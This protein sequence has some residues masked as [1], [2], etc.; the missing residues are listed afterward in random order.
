[1]MMHNPSQGGHTSP[2]PTS[3]RIPPQAHTAAPRRN[4]VDALL[5][6]SL[7]LDGSGWHEPLAD[8]RRPTPRTDPHGP[9]DSDPDLSDD[10][11]DVYLDTT[12]EHRLRARARREVLKATRTKQAKLPAAPPAARNVEVHWN[13]SN[14]QRI[15][16]Y[17]ANIRGNLLDNAQLAFELAR[18]A[19]NG[20]PLVI[21]TETNRMQ[22]ELKDMR[23]PDDWEAYHSALSLDDL[24]VL[25]LDKPEHRD[26]RAIIDDQEAPQQVRD[27]ATTRLEQLKAR[28]ATGRHRAAGITVF[29]K[30]SVFPSIT[31]LQE[32]HSSNSIAIELANNKNEHFVLIAIY[33]PSASHS[34]NNTF[35]GNLRNLVDGL[36]KPLLLAGD[37]NAVASAADR[38]TGN[39]HLAKH[40][41]V[42]L[43]QSLNDLADTDPNTRPEFTFHNAQGYNARLDYFLANDLWCETFAFNAERRN[44]KRPTYRVLP[45][46]EGYDHN[47]ITLKFNYW[48]KKAVTKRPPRVARPKIPAD[49]EMKKEVFAKLN[50]AIDDASLNVDDNASPAVQLQHV[51]TGIANYAESCCTSGSGTLTHLTTELRALL[52]LSEIYSHIAD[53]IDRLNHAPGESALLICAQRQL[54]QNDRSRPA[55]IARL[56]RE[57]QPHIMILKGKW[58]PPDSSLPLASWKPL[59]REVCEGLQKEKKA[60]IRKHKK[61]EIRT[62]VEKFRDAYALSPKQ[63]WRSIRATLKPRLAGITA[64][65]T[66]RLGRSV[67]S[68]DPDDIKREARDLFGKLAKS[69]GQDKRPQF[70]SWLDTLQMG[71]LDDSTAQ[72][73]AK[74]LTLEEISDA[75]DHLALGKATG[76]DRITGEMLRLVRQANPGFA[77]LL[78]AVCN[79][80]FIHGA[81]MPDSW[82]QSNMILLHKK[83]DRLEI[84]NYRPV[85]LIQ[86]IYKVYATVLNNRL[87]EAFESC[88]IISDAQC[89]FRKG[90]SAAQKLWA[91]RAAIGGALANNQPL[92]GVF[93]DMYKCFDTIE[94]WVIEDILTAIGTPHNV[95]RALMDTLTGATTTIIIPTAD[96][97]AEP[98]PVQ[99]GV[100]QG[101]PLSATLAL[102]ALNPMLIAVNQRAREL[103]PRDPLMGMHAYADDADILAGSAAALRQYWDIANHFTSLTNMVINGKKTIAASNAHVPI[104]ARDLPLATPDENGAPTTVTWIGESTPFL[105][106]GVT[107]TMDLDWSHHKRDKLTRLQTEAHLLR[108]RSL[109]TTQLA[110]VFSTMQLAMIS[111]GMLVVPY[112]EKDLKKINEILITKLKSRL[113]MVGKLDTLS[114]WFLARRADGGLGLTDARA[115]YAA[116]QISG[117]ISTLD[118]PESPAKGALMSMI[119]RDN[120]SVEYLNVHNDSPLHAVCKAA[121]DAGI[122]I[123]LKHRA[124][125][126]DEK[127]DMLY[128]AVRLKVGR[129]LNKATWKKELHNLLEDDPKRPIWKGG[130]AE[131]L[132]TLLRAQNQGASDSDIRRMA[133]ETMIQVSAVRFA[134]VDKSTP[135]H[136]PHIRTQLRHAK[137]VTHEGEEW[138]LL[139]G[140][141][142]TEPG[143]PPKSAW[144]VNLT[145]SFRDDAHEWQ[146][147]TCSAR[148]DGRQ[149]N[150]RA[151]IF[152]VT[153]ALETALDMVASE[154][155]AERMGPHSFLVCTDSEATIKSL[156]SFPSLSRNAKRKVPDRDVIR[157][158]LAAMDSLANLGARVRLI[159]IFSHQEEADDE[160]Q[161]KITA[162]QH[163]YTKGTYSCMR[164]GNETVD[165]AAKEALES[166]LSERNYKTHPSTGVEDVYLTDRSSDDWLADGIHPT[167]RRVF[168]QKAIDEIRNQKGKG[169]HVVKRLTDPDIDLKRS[170]PLAKAKEYADHRTAETLL[171]L[172][173]HAYGAT[174]KKRSEMHMYIDR[175]KPHTYATYYNAMYP[176]SA[177]HHCGRRGA[178]P[179]QQEDT[180]HVLSCGNCPQAEML[181]IAAWTRIYQKIAAAIGPNRPANPHALAPFA[182]DT[183]ELRERCVQALEQLDPD[184]TPHLRQLAASP[185]VDGNLGIIPKCLRPAL[186]ELGVPRAL[187][188]ALAD[189]IAIEIHRCIHNVCI[190]RAKVR[191]DEMGQHNLYRQHIL[192]LPPVVVNP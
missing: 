147:F 83:G 8:R 32:L 159:H 151:E 92:W 85:S 13:P 129:R 50:A 178:Q 94:H 179:A 51:M 106:L 160:R 111:Y 42:S 172:R 89:G 35:F 155:Q 128:K 74:E 135:L 153:S 130:Y 93:V 20:F 149:S 121:K 10:P 58:A 145:A 107:F 115:L 5:T 192:G 12:T 33:G 68:S 180:Q 191:A 91:I 127:A 21:H 124:M 40:E 182:C 167:V 97:P 22:H 139:S 28:I 157:R 80:A 11:E 2:P 6:S 184:R 30:R 168:Q 140:D 143:N 104:D 65:R 174:Q 47:P 39:P 54:E 176:S 169:A 152:A 72:K 38:N 82:R 24:L 100:R 188:S 37:F 132:T 114:P 15:G 122:R 146:Q 44:K 45:A 29:A 25:Q 125:N 185:T 109:S 173:A 112:T 133:Q 163:E 41:F 186:E 183:P 77:K 136:I 16:I 141:G 120:C 62:N 3:P 56:M 76:S 98:Y 117:F 170:N 118:G 4:E 88:N 171:A 57:A 154:V 137:K 187:T 161:L 110:Q 36:N 31:E 17:A 7:A 69:G 53:Q 43:A 64:V 59:F 75:I 14:S 86:C 70:K 148:V 34:D 79:D 1:M 78:T 71:K 175:F 26:I 164:T 113:R 166:P 116:Q 102:L 84:S 18:L 48:S 123:C 96:S 181:K 61:E 27:E 101:D 177:C 134:Q 162:Q 189:D 119:L 19:A 67:V 158:A 105:V 66:T 95:L 142:S 150:A 103:E 49:L 165:A 131:H 87:T 60:A 73:M 9:L 108:N 138:V 156:Q 52:R 126:D 144:A 90:R 190:T 99:R 55:A 23:L 81:P 46:P 63:A